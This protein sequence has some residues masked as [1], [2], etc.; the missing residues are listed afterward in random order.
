MC[1]L[2]PMCWKTGEM[3]L[4]RRSAGCLG[5]ILL[6]MRDHFSILHNGDV[7]LCC[8]D[9]EGKTKNEWATSGIHPFVRYSPLMKLG[10]LW[11][12]F[13]KFQLVHP[14]VSSV[15]EA[16]FSLLLLKAVLSIASTQVLKP[17]F[18]KRVRIMNKKAYRGRCL[19][20]L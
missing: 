18:Y 20:R 19:L 8:I 14:T 16:I 13:R 5:R 4:M 6:W 1:F 12:A 10:R 7:I 11:T 9:F 3:P 15:W 2:R 17:F